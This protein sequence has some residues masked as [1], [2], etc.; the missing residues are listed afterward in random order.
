MLLGLSSSRYSIKGYTLI[1]MAVTLAIISI[2]AA[3]AMPFAKTISIRSKEMVLQSSLREI[4]SAI[5]NFHNDWQ[6]GKIN[7]IEK[8]ASP[9]GYPITLDVLVGGVRLS[10]KLE[11][12]KKYMRRIPM[13]PF[14]DPTLRPSL[15]WQRIGYMDAPDTDQWNGEDV[16]D[17]RSLSNRAALDKSLYHDW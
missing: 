7:K 3:V 17:V 2:I 1:E 5:D 6:E 12:R 10:G 9:N 14:A 11:A 13:D 8:I 4:R 15:H 16:Y